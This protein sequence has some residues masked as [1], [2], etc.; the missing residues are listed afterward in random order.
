[1]VLQAGFRHFRRFTGST[2][3]TTGGTEMRRVDDFP[4]EKGTG[5]G[6]QREKGGE[7]IIAAC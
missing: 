3:G 6:G 7:V 2:Q 5:W 4:L 1:M